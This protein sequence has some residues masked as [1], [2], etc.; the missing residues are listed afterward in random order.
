MPHP[1]HNVSPEQ[2]AANRANA[3]KSTGPRS[4]EGKARSAQNARKHGFT[5]TNFAVVRLED[6]QGVAKLTEDLVALHQ[7][8]NSQE[9][10]ALERIALCQQAL[11]RSARLEVGLFTVCLNESYDP[12]G[13][14]VVLMNEELAGNG[15]IQITRAQNRNF[16]M[17]EGFHRMAK[18][19]N[20]WPLFLRYQAQTE[21]LY[22]RAVEDF[23]RL[24]ALREELPNEADSE[25][26][27]EQ[28]ETTCAPEETN[29]SAPEAPAPAPPAPP[30]D[31]ELMLDLSA[32][33][34]ALADR[35]ADTGD[36][37][38][39]SL[40]IQLDDIEDGVWYFPSNWDPE[41][42]AEAPAEAPVD[43]PLAEG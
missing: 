8:R 24:K 31:D 26:Q 3:A 12:L 34:S 33:P 15:D 25:V 1:E 11:L 43:A 16:L 21:R 41:A 19:S 7:P 32:T 29:P 10:F 39:P 28:T 5:A 37:R 17:G 22:R 23:E 27:P 2:L 35:E 30:S 40:P 13:E 9:L 4:A 14:P 20:A 42:P 36:L 6:L 38:E 18:R